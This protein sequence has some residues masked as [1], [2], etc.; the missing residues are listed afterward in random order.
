MNAG[1]WVS[2]YRMQGHFWSDIIQWLGGSM[3]SQSSCVFKERVR[4]IIQWLVSRFQGY[5]NE[6]GRYLSTGGPSVR[7]DETYV[8]PSFVDN[9]SL[10]VNE[11]NSMA[12]TLNVHTKSH[13]VRG[14]PT[15][16]LY[17]RSIYER[18]TSEPSIKK[19]QAKP[20]HVN[21][22]V[23]LDV[24]KKPVE[25]QKLLWNISEEG[26][27]TKGICLWA[28]SSKHTEVLLATSL[29]E[30]WKSYEECL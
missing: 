17:E 27:E 25:Y 11:R 18:P 14:R 6:Q 15:L 12:I 10:D 13:A 21:T 3:A 24:I 8:S 1:S 30:G 29:C 2:N 7:W 28:Y 26:K 20:A 23:Y 4:Y 16:K 19:Y 9:S 22:I 5:K